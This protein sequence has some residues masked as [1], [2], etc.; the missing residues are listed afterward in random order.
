MRNKNLSY[1]L[2]NYIPLYYE[3]DKWV[4]KKVQSNMRK[5]YLKREESKRHQEV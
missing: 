2:K 4:K 5:K 1:Y 3:L